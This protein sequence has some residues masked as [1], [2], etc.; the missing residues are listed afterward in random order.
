MQLL[1]SVMQFVNPLMVFTG[2]DPLERPDLF[3]LL[4]YSV[5]LGLRTTVTPSA[6]PLLTL[7]ALEKFK[8]V[9]VARIAISLDG[10]DAQSHD[11]FRRV[12]GSSK[13][14]FSP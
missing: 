7:E 12:P 9:G 13:N 10:P 3:D 5:N 1:D 11:G 4:R 6:T 8:D 2:G 14:P